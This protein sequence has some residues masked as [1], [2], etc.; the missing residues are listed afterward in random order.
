MA[1]ILVVD[2]EPE[3]CKMLRTF[4]TRK[5]Y[6][7][8]TAF[9][10]EE[11]LSIFKEEKPHIVLLDIKMPKMGGIECL[12]RMREI[13]EEV[14]VIMTTA[15]KDEETGK[16]AMQ[17]GAFDYIVKPISLEYLEYCLKI[18]LIQMAA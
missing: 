12:R 6:E 4:L 18:K 7:V 2:D 5:G 11:A 1:R 10:G 3:V 16:K 13:D 15:V 17:L 14:G 8:H 9:D